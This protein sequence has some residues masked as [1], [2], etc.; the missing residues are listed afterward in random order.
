METELKLLLDPAHTKAL[1]KHPL[2]AR[3]ALVA[4]RTKDQTGVYFDT[5]GH[6]FRKHDAGL[7]VRRTGKEYVQTLKAGGGVSGGLHQRNEWESIVA[8]EQPDLAVL[9][10]MVPANHAW[11][12]RILSPE[13]AARIRPIFATHIKRML[14]DLQ[15]DDGAEVEF[16]LDQGTVEHGRLNVAVCE[17]ELELKSGSPLALFDFA[18]ALMQDIPLRIGIQSKAQRGYTLYHQ[19]QP[20]TDTT[21]G[22][23]TKARPLR[24][25]K[26][27]GLE[28]AFGAIVGNCIE[29]IQANDIADGDP[30]DVERLH[31]MRVG[32][33]RLRSAFTLFRDVIPLPQSLAAEFEW[34][35]TRIGAARDWDVLAG[36]TL[37]ALPADAPAAI[38]LK[39]VQEAARK[40]ATA[41]HKGAVEAV[42]STRYT[43]LVLQF[44]RWLLGA[45]WRDGMDE[46]QRAQLSQSLSRFA[47][48]ML[49]HD[50]KRMKKRG[51]KMEEDPRSRHR[52]RIAAKKMRYDTEFFQAL[53]G[54]KSSRPYLK[55]LS[56]LQDQLGMLNDIAV[57]GELLEQ[58]RGKHPTLAAGI[59]YASGFLAGQ[60]GDGQ[61]KAKRLWKKW[62]EQDLPQ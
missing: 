58:L 53:Y 31:Q 16:V 44:G 36:S 35:S 60:A 41:M 8:G 33:R 51:R 28:Q 48:E 19:A 2:L 7:R 38:N 12:E 25:S 42:A 17:I 55:A 11:R 29:Q 21:S 18:L 54:E 57:A 52:T 40:Q 37:T 56:R 20:E 49:R 5:A 10:E 9:H 6:D 15:L 45:Q 1:I 3:H 47:R 23:A 14:W 27:M 30:Q 62:K 59:A 46:Q 43:A 39:A 22:S 34:L 13:A 32:V 24:L 50:E 61:A 4:P 26:K